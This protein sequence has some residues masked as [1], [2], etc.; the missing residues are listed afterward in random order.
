MTAR[1]QNSDTNEWDYIYKKQSAHNRPLT[2]VHFILPIVITRTMRWCF[3]ELSVSARLYAR[4][5]YDK[6]KNKNDPESNM[7]F[8]QAT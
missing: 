2:F 3:G 4:I 6:T 7:W 8:K 5:S 1:N